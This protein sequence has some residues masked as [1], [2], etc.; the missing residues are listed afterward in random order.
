MSNIPADPAILSFVDDP[1]KFLTPTATVATAVSTYQMFSFG[2]NAR[3]GG[4]PR[5]G[6]FQFVVNPTGKQGVISYDIKWAGATPSANTVW[7]YNLDYYAGAQTNSKPAFLDIPKTVAEKTLL[8]TGALTGCSVIV[9]SLDANT[10]RV[11][12]DS[13]LESSLFYDNVVMAVDWSDYSVFSRE[14][15]ALAFMQFRDGQWRL[16]T[17]L[18]TNSPTGAIL[19]RSSVLRTA[20]QDTYF[21]PSVDSPGSYDHAARRAAFDSSRTESGKRLIR[22]ATEAFSLSTVPNQPDGAFVPFGETISLN[23]PAVN[24]NTAIRNAVEHEIIVMD[25]ERL[26]VMDKVPALWQVLNTQHRPIHDL[27]EPVAL[28]SSKLDYTY[29]WLK[30][31]EARGIDAIVVLDGRLRA[32]LGDTA[33]ERMTSQELEMLSGNADFASGY[34]T[35]KTVAIPGFTSDMDAKA[36]T[37]LFD[38]A[39][40]TDAEKGALVHYISDANAQEYRASVWDKTND[41]LGVFQDSATSTKPMPQDLLLHAIPDEYGGRCYPLVR[42]M[43]VALSQ[44]MFSVD[45]LMVKLTAL[46]TDADLWNATLFMRCLKDLHSSYP[47]AESSKHIGKMELRDAISLLD[48]SKPGAKVVYALNTETHA[49]LLAANDNGPTLP[50]SFHFYD[51]NFLLATF[52]SS[53]VLA[54]T[55]SKHLLTYGSVY[56]AE[57]A[58]GGASQLFTVVELDPNQLAQISFDSG[59]QVGDFCAPE[60]LNESITIKSAPE[61]NLP[62]PDRFTTQGTLAATSAL[63]DGFGL[64]EGWR[65]ATEDLETSLGLQGNWMPVLE[66]LEDLGGGHYQIQFVNLDDPNE[67]RIVSTDDERIQQFKQYI[68]DQLDALRKVYDLQ[69]GTFV[70]KENVP[71]GE[72]IDGLNAMFVVKTVIDMYSGHAGGANSNSN[73]AMALKVQSYFNLAQM[74]RTTLGDVSHV[75]QLAQS[76]IKNEQVAFAELS[77]IGKAF[78]RASDGLGTL[79]S[80]ASVVFD[81]YELSNAQDDVQRAVFGTQLGFDSASLLIG[82]ASLGA[83][84]I[85]ASTAAAL[86][87]GAGAVVAGL[88]VGFMGLADAFGQVAEDAKT[89]GKYFGDAEKAYLAGG[90]KYD[91]ANEALIPLAYAVISS[92]NLATGTVSFDSQYIYRTHS[93]STGSGAIN[94]FFW[95]GDY[96]TVVYDKSQAINVRAGIGAPATGTLPRGYNNST[97]FVLPATPKSYIS[98]GW[99]MLPGATTRGDYGFDVIRRL[100]EDKRFDYDFYIFPAERTIN[101]LSHEYV[102]TSVTIQLSRNAIRVQVPEFPSVMQG[103]MNYTLQGAGAAYTVGLE[104]GASITLGSTNAST[105]W[106]LDCTHLSFTT[107]SVDSNGVTVGGVRVNIADHNFASMIIATPTNDMLKVN[108][109]NPH[110]S[111]VSEDAS[112]FSGSAALQAQLDKLNDSQLLDSAFVLLKKYTTP[113]GEAVGDAYYEASRRRFLYSTGLPQT[114]QQG[115]GIV[116]A[117]DDDE[118]YFYNLGAQAIW[119]VN[120]IDGSCTAKYRAYYPSAMRTL[121]QVWLEDDNVFAT[122]RHVLGF[123]GLYHS[124][125]TYILGKDSMIL[126]SIIGDPPLL[127]QLSFLDHVD[128]P[129][130]QMIADYALQE[131]SADVSAPTSGPTGGSDVQ[132]SIDAK[133]TAVLGKEDDGTARCFW[134]RT[135]DGTVIT[136]NFTPTPD[137]AYAG[138]TPPTSS[139]PEEFYFYS[140]K[141]QTITFQ[142][143]SGTKAGPPQTVN[144]PSDFGN[145]ANLLSLEGRMFAISDS[146]VVLRLTQ[147]GVFFLEAVNQTWI[148]NL[149]NSAD[150]LPWWTKLQALADSHSA[151]IVAVLGLTATSS[152]SAPADS[153]SAPA[154]PV[155]YIDGKFVIVVSPSLDNKRLDVLGLSKGPVGDV[156]WIAYKDGD[157]SGHLYA[158]P[159][160]TGA[161][162]DL[163]SPTDPTVNLATIS[164]AQILTSMQSVPFKDVKMT[165]DG[166]QYTALDGRIFIITDTQTVTLLGVDKTWQAANAANLEA[167]LVTLA[168]QTE[169]NHGEVFILQGD[170][171]DPPAWYHIVLGKAVRPT[172]IPVTWADQPVWL[173]VSI[174]AIMGWFFVPVKNTASVGVTYTVRVD[175]PGGSSAPVD[176]LSFTK[177]LDDILILVPSPGNSFSYLPGIWGVRTAV[178]LQCAGALMGYRVP[179]ASWDYYESIVVQD[180][181]ASVR[182][183]PDSVYLDVTNPGVLLAKKIGEDLVVADT[184]NGHSLTLRKAFGADP[185]YANVAVN[186][187]LGVDVTVQTMMHAQQWLQKVTGSSTPADVTLQTIAYAVTQPSS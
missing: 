82:V 14:G 97:I 57:G 3:P 146:G 154:V 36:M 33:G 7:A 32:P 60:S 80:A 72:G 13:R 81:A 23:N 4:V 9:T 155:W 75:V 132:A 182:T 61:F 26:A 87:G 35:Y 22:V 158:Q 11:F 172:N 111:I 40:L 41:V 2:I 120:P 114:L 123:T 148:A 46:T 181:N 98:Y 141:H 145:L 149:K 152:T 121:V 104:T 20:L 71:E 21:P 185:A 130:D 38:S 5:E 25:D 128:Y 6:Y 92:V 29:L 16:I 169:W 30:Q 131:T 51:P 24:H 102:G 160:A 105:S 59:L 173:G 143:G 164:P 177:R 129:L 89:V 144:F 138:S 69:G 163:F 10:Y 126:V 180:H 168:T 119:R 156:A 183:Q 108:F 42:A 85:G 171:S 76:I 65:R 118:V 52:D 67:K 27:V 174:E 115:N 50:A 153:A 137:I 106:I 139:G 100:E 74:G 39:Q 18:Q 101:T 142:A 63:L 186:T 165:E 45:Q 68:S 109:T 187:R 43:A 112:N 1:Q 64:A 93:G 86:L 135:G 31:K 83:G 166:L 8:F 133:L 73:L 95:A 113:S 47:A 49:M 48:V 58:E 167:T 184:T 78:G 44:S 56:G 125:L 12:H 77:T 15:L 28:D 117:T 96:P 90:Y 84:L 91:S 161:V 170:P 62:S 140:I 110:T 136:P 122:Y 55:V 66:S 124:D 176:G 17:Q 159:L 34:D 179:E 107:A 134:I 53:E 99:Q 94:Y 116:V 127:R 157:G 19:P 150:H 103:K 178:I 151:T 54:S 162:T 37:L 70:E 79:L 147:G 175:V 88:A